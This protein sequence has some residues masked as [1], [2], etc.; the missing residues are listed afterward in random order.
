[1]AEQRPREMPKKPSI[2]IITFETRPC[3]FFCSASWWPILLPLLHLLH[4]LSFCAG[5]AEWQ[6]R[7]FQELVAG[8]ACWGWDV[9]CLPGVHWS[10]AL[11]RK[12]LCLDPASCDHSEKENKAEVQVQK[13]KEK[14]L[15]KKLFFSSPA[16]SMTILPNSWKLQSHFSDIKKGNI[17]KPGQHIPFF[18]SD[19]NIKISSCFMRQSDILLCCKDHPSPVMASEAKGQKTQLPSCF[20]G[21]EEAGI[22]WY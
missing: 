11:F 1:M 22:F 7:S 19:G 13:E 2:K 20:T 5:V 9:W 14:S 6:S 3:S 16:L 8:G 21:K 15:E 17:S 4:C 12:S 10:P 18:F